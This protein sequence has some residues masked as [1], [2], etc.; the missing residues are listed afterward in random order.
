MCVCGGRDLKGGEGEVTF[1]SP[2]GSPAL[3]S[4]GLVTPE[5]KNRE[6]KGSLPH[7]PLANL[8]FEPGRRGRDKKEEL[9]YF[10]NCL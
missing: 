8:Q 6:P 5:G 7:S 2:E 4:P 3:L 10:Q 1:L 9:Y